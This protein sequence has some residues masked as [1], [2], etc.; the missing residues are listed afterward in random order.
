MDCT[1]KDR[2]ALASV[3]EMTRIGNRENLAD[4][5]CR[6][7]ALTNLVSEPAYYPT[8]VALQVDGDLARSVM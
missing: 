2:V 6:V 4:E 3:V 7:A 8:G 1:I 5:R